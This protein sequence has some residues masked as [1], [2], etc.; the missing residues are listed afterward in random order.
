MRIIDSTVA[1]NETDESPFE[2]EVYQKSIRAFYPLSAV[3]F[4]DSITSNTGAISQMTHVGGLEPTKLDIELNPGEQV[5][6]KLGVFGKRNCTGSQVQLSYGY[7]TNLEES[8]YTRELCIPFLLT[9]VQSL[10][11]RNVDLLHYADS[12]KA[13]EKP[14]VMAVTE[15][16]LSVEEIMMNPRLSTGLM[17]DSDSKNTF[18]LTFDFRNEW[19]EPFKVTFDIFDD[20]VSLNPT[21]STTTLLHAGVTKRF[22]ER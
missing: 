11:F 18:L 12:H 5:V 13:G 17:H 16:S 1:N 21:S 19:D 6:V 20:P 9:V 3:S 8:F 4:P 10:S 7:V 2:T 14:S 22:A 15:R